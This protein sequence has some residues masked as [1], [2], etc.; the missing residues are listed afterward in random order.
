[1]PGK[2]SP[3]DWG[4]K[5]EVVAKVIAFVIITGLLIALVILTSLLYIRMGETNDLLNKAS[6]GMDCTTAVLAPLNA[7][8]E[9]LTCV[10]NAINAVGG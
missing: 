3:P 7:N 1:M 6:D 4:W 2:D 10:K 5:V 9:N 8:A